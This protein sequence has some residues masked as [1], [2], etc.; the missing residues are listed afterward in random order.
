[1]LSPKDSP[2]V[3]VDT[4]DWSCERGLGMTDRGGLL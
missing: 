1:M 2:A 4:G 3:I